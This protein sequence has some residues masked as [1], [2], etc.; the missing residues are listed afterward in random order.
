MRAATALRAIAA[1]IAVFGVIDPAMTRAQRPPLDVDLAVPRDEADA[2]ATPSPNAAN[3]DARRRLVRE[4]RAAV[5]GDV[6]LRTRDFGAGEPLPCAVDVPCVVVT[7]AVVAPRGGLARQRPLITLPLVMA[8][9]PG[10]VSIEDV[11][12]PA[13]HVDGSATASVTLAATGA[14]GRETRL[15]IRD[16]DVPVGATQHT[17]TGE[18]P[19]TLSVP[20]WPTRAG[21]R[22]LSVTATTTGIG[23]VAQ[24]TGAVADVEVSEAAWPVLVVEFRPSW[25][26]TFVRRALDADARFVVD[27]HAVL[28]PGVTTARGR[29]GLDDQ[30]VAA[31]KVVVAGG[32]EALTERDVA[33]F[34]RFV[35]E[36]GG[37]LVLVP[38]AP[39]AGPAARLLPGRWRLRLDREPAGAD[40]LQASE[41][42]L[43][44]D[45]AAGD[46]VLAAHG[47]APAIVSRPI[48][49]GRLIV[50]GAL[51]AWRYR[52]TLA[53]NPAAAPPFTTFW[54]GLLAD[55]ARG[56]GAAVDVRVSHV[57][58]DGDATVDV[59]AR[60]VEPRATWRASA[61]LGCGDEDVVLRLWPQPRTGHFRA[62]APWPAPGVTCEVTAAVD[63]IGDARAALNAPAATRA[64]AQRI[65]DRL[66]AVAVRTGGINAA[67]G[68]VHAVAQ[69][70]AALRPPPVAM[71]WWP[72]RAW[73]WGMVVA[74]ALGGEWWLR[75]RSG[76]R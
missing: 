10:L 52:A 67:P 19:A 18:S 70:L 56:T 14:E 48:G 20:W 63:G 65:A 31:A 34:E 66:R 69:A 68:D 60:S 25:A 54:R 74:L 46:L 22:V 5:A 35:A 9:T 45:L 38:D 32:L 75:R 43:A 37:A 26:A 2:A 24:T 6:R 4:L 28:A 50:V 7:D 12:V 51:D 57:A 55:L 1:G 41:W 39:V 76:A 42:L 17:W 62:W 36:R 16:G 21:R 33:R 27:A 40:G 13:A 3:D 71:P 73:W 30:R 44:S 23:G 72:M 47:D 11:V 49:E 58:G 8:A 53:P 29:I 59:Q 64:E 15:E 61:R